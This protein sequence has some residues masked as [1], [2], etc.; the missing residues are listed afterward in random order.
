[1]NKTKNK[2]GNVFIIA[3]CICIIFALGIIIFN[4]LQNSTYEDNAT[5]VLN[6]L[7]KQLP[8]E[9]ILKGEVK[10]DTTSSIENFYDNVEVIGGDEEYNYVYEDDSYKE[11]YV[12]AGGVKYIGIINIPSLDITLPVTDDWNLDLMKSSTCRYSGSIVTSDLI[13]CGHNMAAFFSPIKG[14][15]VDDVIIFID[16]SGNKFTYNVVSIDT[17]GGYDI[18]GMKAGSDDWDITLFTCTYGGKN[19]VAVRALLKE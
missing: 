16:A 7:E 12:E 19:R 10:T 4:R 1:M 9:E 14:M 2:L 18:E 8:Y 17:V 5:E 6:E 13:I 3:G 11:T 15:E